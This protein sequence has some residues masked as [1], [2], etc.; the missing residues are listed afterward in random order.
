MNE[1]LYKEPVDKIINDI[2][3]SERNTILLLGKR[4]SGKTTVVNEYINSSHDFNTKVVNCSLKEGEHRFIYDSNILYLYHLCLIMEKILDMVKKEDINI[5]SELMYYI[6]FINNKKNEI[7]WMIMSND[8]SS[9]Y[10]KIGK[11]AIDNQKEL[12]SELV[13]IVKEK[14]N[15]SYLTIVIDNIDNVLDGDYNRLY[16]QFIFDTLQNNVKLIITS[17][18]MNVL[19]NVNHILYSADIE[20]INYSENCKFVKEILDKKFTKD[21]LEKGKF[22]FDKRILL[23]LDDDI[24]NNM[25][26]RSNGNLNIMIYALEDFY[27]NLDKIRKSEYARYLNSYINT[28][29]RDKYILTKSRKLHM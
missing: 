19:N 1:L 25:I 18:D 23:L 29:N 4:G 28:E 22:S 11:S 10:S 6:T 26:F 15:I 21:F 14:L 2:K 16:Q 12:F 7:E 24:I 17:S 27:K 20:I 5:Y 9:K 13:S 3:K 8:Y